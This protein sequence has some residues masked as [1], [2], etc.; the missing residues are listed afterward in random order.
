M[1]EW[2]WLISK[3]RRFEN[4]SHRG[5]GRQTDKLTDE[6]ALFLIDSLRNLGKLDY[7]GKKC[8]QYALLLD[9]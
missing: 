9:F 7:F 8:M 1:N 4:Y 6:L 3:F 2:M 5:T